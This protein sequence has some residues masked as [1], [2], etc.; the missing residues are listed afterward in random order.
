[1]TSQLEQMLDSCESN[2][3]QFD[4]FVRWLE[5]DSASDAPDRVPTPMFFD[6]DDD[7]LPILT[8][9][10]FMHFETEGEKEDVKEE[11]QALFSPLYPPS[12][13]LYTV[14]DEL[15]NAPLDEL[16]D[17]L[18]NEAMV[19]EPLDELMDSKMDE[20]MGTPVVEKKA[21]GELK[22]RFCAN[23]MAAFCS[24]KTFWTPIGWNGVAS[25]QFLGC[26]DCKLTLKYL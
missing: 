24:N 15:K 9:N 16:V 23:C 18:E 26:S 22:M 17:E 5:D 11:E 8:P 21:A 4:A 1:M 25:I 2:E 12:S 10:A 14:L 20:T 13:P 19:N 3:A 7:D 6:F